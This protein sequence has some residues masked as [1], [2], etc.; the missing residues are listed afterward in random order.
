MTP[1]GELLRQ[2]SIIDYTKT[3]IQGEYGSLDQFIRYW[4]GLQ[5]KDVI[6]EL[7][8]DRGIDLEALKKDQGISILDILKS[9]RCMILDLVNSIREFL[10]FGRKLPF[11]SVK[12]IMYL[13]I[14]IQHNNSPR[15]ILYH[16]Y[17]AC[18]SHT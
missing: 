10:E 18:S 4:S 9:N 14:F 7:L 8:K 13:F 3:N 17:H 1:M 5:K 12:L 15:G 11:S 16:S 2:E 6:T